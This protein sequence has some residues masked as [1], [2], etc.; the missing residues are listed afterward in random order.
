M[1]NFA[2]SIEAELND[3]SVAFI[4]AGNLKNEGLN[5]QRR[6]VHCYRLG[7]TIEAP[8]RAGGTVV[9]THPLEADANIFDAGKSRV[10]TV[11]NRREHIELRIFAESEETLDVL[12]DNIITAI[13]RSAPNGGIEWEEYTWIENEIGQRQP[14]IPL[15]L[16]A[17]FPVAEE[18][19]K[20]T[21]LAAEDFEA[22]WV[23]PPETEAS[24]GPD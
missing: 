5:H 19:K 16:W 9:E 14:M 23:I 1:T 7:G 20:L 2:A 12:L 10:P 3:P 21:I 6:R 13:D 4:V 11:W 15:R 17:M 18:I 22:R 24:P 8:E